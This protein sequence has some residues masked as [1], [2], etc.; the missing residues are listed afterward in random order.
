[1]QRLR[2]IDCRLSRLPSVV[3]L[4]QADIP[5]IA[6]FVNSAQRRLLMCKEAG[7]EGWWG[8]FAEISFLANRHH[9]YIT[10]PREIARIEAMSVCDRPVPVNN[11]FFEYLEFV[12]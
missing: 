5:G 1:M 10:L 4:C 9:P 2:L 7:D 6:Q 11:Q 3:G 8:T 12:S